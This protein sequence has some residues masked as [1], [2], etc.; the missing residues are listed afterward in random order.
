MSALPTDL[1]ELFQQIDSEVTEVTEVTEPPRCPVHMNGRICNQPGVARVDIRCPTCGAER[2][3]KYYC[4]THLQAGLDREL[5][6]RNCL[7]SPQQ[8]RSFWE[9][10]SYSRLDSK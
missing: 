3:E 2:H 1:D 6:C 5:L 7:R 4:E 9:L 10:L 8:I